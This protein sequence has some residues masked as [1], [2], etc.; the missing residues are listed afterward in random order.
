M[1]IDLFLFV[2]SF[3]APFALFFLLGL[4]RLIQWLFTR[5]EEEVM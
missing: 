3:V 2:F 5:E 4:V 1:D